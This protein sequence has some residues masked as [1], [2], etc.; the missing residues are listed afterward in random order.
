MA[1]P[2]NDPMRLSRP[3]H[4]A[5]HWMAVVRIEHASPGTADA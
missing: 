3:T 2:S 5:S 1:A 4:R